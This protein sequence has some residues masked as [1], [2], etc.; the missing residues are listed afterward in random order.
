[1]AAKLVG[2]ARKLAALSAMRP[3]LRMLPVE[4][5]S[6]LNDSTDDVRCTDVSEEENDA[7]LV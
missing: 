3:L 6:K 2:L 7:D 1:M 4:S 5:R